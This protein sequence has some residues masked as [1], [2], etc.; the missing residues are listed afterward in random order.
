[1]DAHSHPLDKAQVPPELLVTI[2]PIKENTW[3]N[4][5]L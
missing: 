5:W 1:M 3:W 4:L 2:P